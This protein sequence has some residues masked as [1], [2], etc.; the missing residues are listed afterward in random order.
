TEDGTT[1][2]PVII[3]RAIY[4]SFERFFAIITEQF[5]GKWPFWLSPNQF[6]IIPVADK[7]NEFAKDLCPDIRVLSGNHKFYVDIDLSDNT[8]KKKIRNAQVAEYNY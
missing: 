4:G 5:D 3:H 1:E 7:Y 6:M 2:R 8:L